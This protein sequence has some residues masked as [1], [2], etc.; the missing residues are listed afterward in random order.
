MRKQYRYYSKDD[1]DRT[2]FTGDAA[3]ML[4]ILPRS[5]KQLIGEICSEGLTRLDASSWNLYPS[6]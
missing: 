4:D 1:S 3:T 6:A 2:I 5:D